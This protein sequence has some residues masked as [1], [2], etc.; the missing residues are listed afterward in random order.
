MSNVNKANPSNLNHQ[1]TELTTG[2][3]GNLLSYGSI[4]LT[5]TLEL[6]DK[7]LVENNIEWKKINTLSNVS[8]LKENT[9]LWGRISLSSTDPNM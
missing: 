1:N 2:N 9:T 3:I 6:F 5:L 8:F 4:N 7:D